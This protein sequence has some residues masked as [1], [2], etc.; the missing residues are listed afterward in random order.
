MKHDCC[1]G[2]VGP[3]LG[4]EQP[5]AAPGHKSLCES[6]VNQTPLALKL[7]WPLGMGTREN[8][9]RLAQIWS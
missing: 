8:L 1:S 6:A 7:S 3:V 4:S 9:C 2:A 5:K